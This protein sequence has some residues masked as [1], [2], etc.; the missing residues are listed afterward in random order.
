MIKTIELKNSE[1]EYRLTGEGQSET[2]LFLH[3]LG[4]N[5]SQ[6]QHQHQ[7]FDKDYQ[8]ISVNL[9]GHGRS[10]VLRRPNPAAFEL[11]KMALDVIELLEVLG[12]NQV[13]FVGNS[14]GGNVGYE[15]LKLKPSLFSSFTT[16]GTTAQLSTS[17]ITFKIMK[18][19]YIILNTKTIGNLAKA[20][21]QT[22]TSREKI[23]EMMSH[24]NRPILLS[25]LPNIA[26]FN[27]LDVIK[28]SS[29]PSIL[30]KGEF[31]KDI[32]KALES[33]IVE[34]EHRGNFK[35]VEIENVGHFANLDNPDKFNWVLA[36]FIDK[37]SKTM[38]RLTPSAH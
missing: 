37:K 31:D 9:R 36:E 6:F 3:G 32:N 30:I 33:T 13:N 2:I 20:A 38:A 21:G 4:A 26:N 35:I 25:I 23:K 1:L 27:Y 10:R 29:V 18:Y 16:F 8:V 14:M 7:Y 34:F 17:E 22:D 24:V 19:T 12:I 11:S 15:I 5:L 28:T